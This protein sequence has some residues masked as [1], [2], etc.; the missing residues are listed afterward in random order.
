[1]ADDHFE[2]EH[3]S[4]GSLWSRNH[5]TPAFDPI[6]P[7]TVTAPAFDYGGAAPT[8]AAAR[9]RAHLHANHV[10]E[11][12]AV[13][14]AQLTP[15]AIT[16]AA[17]DAALRA[18]EIVRQQFHDANGTTGAPRPNPQPSPTTIRATAPVYPDIFPV[19]SQVPP[20]AS[21]DP[22]RAR[23]APGEITTQADIDGAV[24]A[25]SGGPRRP[26]IIQ[27]MDPPEPEQPGRSLKERLEASRI[28]RT[29][30]AAS[31]DIT[32]R[33]AMPATTTVPS[34]TPIVPAEDRGLQSVLNQ[35]ALDNLSRIVPG[36][37]GAP[38]PRGSAVHK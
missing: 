24:L 34:A 10:D 1:M 7:P 21:P 16:T 12:P 13:P 9:A 20:V 4:E 37:L 2:R 14:N 30:L 33:P 25:N 27:S 18:E 17:D 19:D 36:I 28:G 23:R 6:G 26:P 5:A 22:A 3:G 38:P 29:V 11:L 8:A 35:D 31:R 32:V 15:S